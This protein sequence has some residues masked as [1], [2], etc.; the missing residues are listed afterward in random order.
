MEMKTCI[1]IPF[2]Q[3]SYEGISGPTAHHDSEAAALTRDCADLHGRLSRGSAAQ[4][5]GPEELFCVSGT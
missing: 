4:C 2:P 1:P 5:L 3:I